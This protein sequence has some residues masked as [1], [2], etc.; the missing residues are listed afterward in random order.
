[1]YCTQIKLALGCVQLVQI[2]ELYIKLKY[3]LKQRSL[4][5][6]PTTIRLFAGGALL[7]ILLSL[8][9]LPYF[10]LKSLQQFN[11]LQWNRILVSDSYK[12][13]QF[14]EARSLESTYG[15]ISGCEFFIL[16]AL[17]VFVFYRLTKLLNESEY[18]NLELKKQRKDLQL[19][20]VAV[21]FGYGVRTVLQFFYGHYYLV[22]PKQY[23][24]WMLYDALN[25]VMDI[26]NVLYVYWK[27]FITFKS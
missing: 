12:C 14:F 15:I 4:I 22:I 16:T 11:Q 21:F 27:H 18:L 20:W 23:T 6:L 10:N 13:Q 25:P 3:I 2:S 1:M 17:F 19:F 26:P 7:A 24:R 5:S 8:S 9:I